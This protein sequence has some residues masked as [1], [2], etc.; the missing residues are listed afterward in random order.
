V[1]FITRLESRKR[2]KDRNREY[3]WKYKL[4]H[5]C[6]ECMERDVRLLD[7]HHRNPDKKNK[8]ISRLVKD[9]ASLKTLQKEI[10]KCDVLCIRCHRLKHWSGYIYMGNYA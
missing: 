4:S 7:F 9:G 10:N 1:I 6:V 5:P 2:I 8:N 3:V